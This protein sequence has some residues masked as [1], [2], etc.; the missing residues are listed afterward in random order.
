MEILKNLE[1]IGIT[2][3]A[4]VFLTG[5]AN[6]ILMFILWAVYLSIVNVNLLTY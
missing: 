2:I 1:L 3:S 5:V 4:F 6:A